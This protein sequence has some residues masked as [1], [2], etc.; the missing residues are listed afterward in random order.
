MA[1]QEFRG[2][3]RS[4][5]A[6]GG[7]GVTYTHEDL[8][9]HWLPMVR[10]ARSVLGSRHEAEECAATAMLQVLERSR[11]DVENLEALLVTV[12]KRRA[13]DRLRSLERNRRRDIRVASQ[14]A[15]TTDDV[16]DRVVAQA[17]AQWMTDQARRRL[18]P[19]SFRI[20]AA[21]AANEDL[22]AVAARERLTLRA[23]QSDLF[24][25]RRLLRAVWARTTLAVTAIWSL[26][27][28]GC[29]ATPALVSAAALLWL[30]PGLSHVD[31]P[32]ASPSTE[33]VW[34]TAAPRGTQLEAKTAQPSTGPVRAF[35]ASSKASHLDSLRPGEVRKNVLLH[36]S[37]PA[38]GSTVLMEH[39]GT[40]PQAGPVGTIFECAANLQL[41]PH[42]LGC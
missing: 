11:H 21:V 2:S 39:H 31:E 17:E 19:Q 27:R 1:E 13:V 15:L 12:A 5:G 41:D 18:S 35:A 22:V 26:A 34:E 33:S 6:R 14:L 38:G 42:N 10:V 9:G 4:A 8:E 40:G 16:A 23:A 3:C 7:D 30:A 24:R 37:D 32:Q 29:V 28:R 36:A 25:S 20:L